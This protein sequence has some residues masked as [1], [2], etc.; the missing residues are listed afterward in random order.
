MDLFITVLMRYDDDEHRN[1]D[2]VSSVKVFKHFKDAYDHIN[3]ETIEELIDIINDR[4]LKYK[5]VKKYVN[6][7]ENEY[8]YKYKPEILKNKKLLDSM[9]EEYAVGNFVPYKFMWK[10]YPYS[11]E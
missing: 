2:Y 5:E 8:K 9:Y 3:K 11:I 10:I 4:E 1:P 6:K 7:T